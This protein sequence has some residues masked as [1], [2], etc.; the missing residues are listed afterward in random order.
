MNKFLTNFLHV[1]ESI[2]L[3]IDNIINLLFQPLYCIARILVDVCNVWEI[4]LEEEQQEEE[5]NNKQTTI[6]FRR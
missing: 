6:G 2:E 5:N 4:N 3:T 1:V